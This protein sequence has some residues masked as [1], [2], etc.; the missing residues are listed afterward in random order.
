MREVNTSI[1]VVIPEYSGEKMVHE[2]VSRIVASLETIT[3]EYEIILVN[4]ASPD[5][6]W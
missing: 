1:S 4:D 5:N 6:A 3:Y 2:L